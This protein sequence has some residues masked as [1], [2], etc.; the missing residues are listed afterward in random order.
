MTIFVSVALANI[1]MGILMIWARVYLL[2]VTPKSPLRWLSIFYVFIGIYWILAY[3][4]VLHIELNFIPTL[5]LIT[6]GT[7]IIR[8][9]ITL[10]LA[11]IASDAL[12]TARLARDARR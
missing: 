1:F 7:M 10:T 3:V 9:G 12:L 8:P 5:E 6:I 4:A 11:V 2:N